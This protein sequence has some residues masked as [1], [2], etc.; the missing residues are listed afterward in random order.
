[1]DRIIG[2]F[3]DAGASF[4]TFHPEATNHVDRSLQ[5][6]LALRLFFFGFFRSIYLCHLCQHTSE[7]TPADQLI[8]AIFATPPPP[9]PNEPT[10]LIKSKG[11]KAGLV[12]NPATS[13]DYAKY[14]LAF[15]DGVLAF[16]DD[17]L[18]SL[19]YAK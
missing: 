18:A 7:R 6:R 10:Q 8:S 2:D 3:A 12:F 11:C 15:S 5:V 19:D 9:P 1:M 16:S 17:V 4:I 14:V 13:L